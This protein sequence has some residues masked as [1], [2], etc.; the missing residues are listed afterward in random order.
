[1]LSPSHKVPLAKRIVCAAAGALAGYAL[2]ASYHQVN[3]F[4]TEALVAIIHSLQPLAAWIDG[5]TFDF[6]ALA[7]ITV[8]KA[9]PGSIGLGL[10]SGMLLRSL[11]YPR[12]FAYAVLL[13]P[14]GAYLASFALLRDLT[15][16]AGAGFTHQL[17]ENRSH[18]V[19]IG[20]AI[21]TLFF[22]TLLAAYTCSTG[23]KRPAR[24]RHATG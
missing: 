7:L 11:P 14:I 23:K 9:A 17:W 18:A 4:S 20:F 8:A 22:S 12:W 10:I 13:F 24:T 5:H 1:M 2:W 15:G 19:L 16:M 21:Y 3:W 6:V